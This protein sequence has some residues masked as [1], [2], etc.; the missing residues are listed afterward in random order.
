[1]ILHDESNR[2]M[3]S[4]VIPISISDSDNIMYLQS[5]IESFKD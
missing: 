4:V 3:N 5:L 1:M 2:L